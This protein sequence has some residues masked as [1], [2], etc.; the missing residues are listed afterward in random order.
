MDI[1]ALEGEGGRFGAV[2]ARDRDN[3]ETHRYPA[4][5]AFVFI[6]LQ[7]ITDFLGDAVERDAGGFL[8]TATNMETSMPGVF[9]AGDVRSGSTKQLGS[10]V[11]DGI[12]A[13]LM[14]RRH[15]EA[16]RYKAP[17]LVDA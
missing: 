12:A 13:L 2:V 14:T 9:A 7:P 3:G 6:G 15:L 17:A 5:A 10:A 16:H 11:G 4:A 8:V 1:V